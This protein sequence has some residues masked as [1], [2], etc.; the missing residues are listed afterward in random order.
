MDVAPSKVD[1]LLRLAKEG[2]IRARDLSTAAIPRAYLSR[3]C[4]RGDLVRIDRGV[5]RLADARVTELHG[6]VQVAKRVP[7]AI[8]CL[9]SALQVHE[10]TTEVP[11]A[12]WIQIDRRDRAPSFKRPKLEIVRASGPAREHGI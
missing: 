6:L 12:V 2:V 1:A 5:Y 8:V 3:L 11:H 9:L 10:L 7:H 4:S